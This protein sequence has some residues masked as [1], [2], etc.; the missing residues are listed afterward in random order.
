LTFIP[1]LAKDLR[2]FRHGDKAF[3]IY[4]PA[5]DGA[6]W[7]RTVVAEER[8]LA[9]GRGSILLS[10]THRHRYEVEIDVDPSS[11]GR[12]IGRALPLSCRQI[13]LLRLVRRP[14]CERGPASSR[15]A[16]R[17][18]FGVHMI[19]WAFSRLR[20]GGHGIGALALARLVGYART[21]FTNLRS[22]GSAAVVAGTGARLKDR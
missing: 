4:G 10:A 18:R 7:R 22:S 21:D 11:R 1:A 17:S 14:I 2:L 12:G 19:G 8:G 9:V 13:R 16:G 6:H 20:S 15:S 5:Q 3:G